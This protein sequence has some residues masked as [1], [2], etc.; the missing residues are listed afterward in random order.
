[1]ANQLMVAKVLS[2]KALHARGWSQRRIARELGINRESVARHLNVGSKPAKAPTGS[3][4]E[5]EDQKSHE[6][7]AIKHVEA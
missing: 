2:I 6:K 5:Q 1:M 7:A 3:E 4:A